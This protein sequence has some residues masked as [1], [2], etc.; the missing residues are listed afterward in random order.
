[1]PRPVPLDAAQGMA[2]PMPRMRML[3]GFNAGW[4]EFE[5]GEGGSQ[6]GSTRVETVLRALV[7]RVDS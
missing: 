1:M 2:N 7:D 5:R 6:K 4:I 3:D